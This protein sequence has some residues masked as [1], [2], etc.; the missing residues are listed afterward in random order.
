[1]EQINHL[2][3]KRR[4]LTD[5]ARAMLDGRVHL[6]EGVRRICTLRFEVQDP[7]NEVFLPILAIDSETDSYP[8]GAVR[9]TC[10]P[11][12]LKRADAEIESYLDEARNDILQACREIINVFS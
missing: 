12:Y 9:A 10:S 8:F 4:E 6:I 11:S 7:E 1:M 3:V 5:M 2:F